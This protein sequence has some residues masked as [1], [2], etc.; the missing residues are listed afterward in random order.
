LES[1]QEELDRENRARKD[2]GE[3]TEC[4]PKVSFNMQDMQRPNRRPATPTS[5]V[6]PNQFEIGE[7]SDEEDEEDDMSAAKDEETVDSPRV[8]LPDQA[9][10][11]SSVSESAEDAVPLQLRGMSE[12]A[13]GKLPEGAFQ[14]QG[15]TTSLASH[16]SAN[17]ASTP[18]AGFAPTHAWIDS[19]LP[20]LPLHTILTVIQQLQP[21]L[22]SVL[23]PTPPPTS[24]HTS[25][26]ATDVAPLLERIRKAKLRGIEPTPV[27][28]HMFEWSPL[29]LGWYESLLWGFIFVSE[30]HV[31]KGAGT[32]GVWNGTAVRLFR[33]QETAPEGPS[34][35]APRGGVD[36]IGSNLIER[37]GNVTMRRRDSAQ[38]SRRGSTESAGRTA[39]I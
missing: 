37:L 7:D 24:S 8:A 19:W 25:L 39:V 35:L 10:R 14:R 23:S 2:R 16:I 13:R 28:T 22:R 17:G 32:V 4:S 26:H 20:F 21:E 11:T 6:A 15:S 33:V 31:S 12:K 9:S 34:L 29:A 38:G 27:R 30:R 3:G 36:A 5:P 1:G 18:T